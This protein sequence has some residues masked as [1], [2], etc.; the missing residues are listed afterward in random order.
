[1]PGPS[2]AP[3]HWRPEHNLI[4]C[5]ARR[6]LDPERR[7]R[8][9]TLT[10]ESLDWFL[11]LGTAGD[12]G[13]EPLLYWHLNSTGGVVVPPIWS[14][15][16]K[17]AFERNA[18]RNLYMSGQL[19]RV[20]DSF[21]ANGVCGIPYK[22]PTLA[23][24]AYGNLALRAS[25][26]LDILVRQRDLPRAQELLLAL[27]YSIDLG[28]M[29]NPAKHSERIPGQYRF[30]WDYG[31]VLVELHT[32]RTL[33]YFPAPLDMDHL[34]KRLKPIPLGGR[35]VPTFSPEDLLTVLCVHGAKHFWDRLQWI[36]DIAELA[37][38]PRG[39]NW[40]LAIERAGQMQSRRMLFLGLSLAHELLGANLPEEVLWQIER[41]RPVQSLAAQVRA[42]LFR[43]DEASPNAVRRMLFRIRTREKVSAG[44]RYFCR[45][46]TAPTEEDWSR[47]RLPSFLSPLYVV[48]RP[49]HLMRRYGLGLRH[50]PSRDLAWFLPTPTSIAE[51]M[52]ELAQVR[53]NDVLYDLG[54]G[55]GQIV[56]TAAKRYGI[57]CVGVDIDP[58]RIAEAKANARREG[59]KHLVKFLQQDAKTAV[60]TPATIVTLYLTELGSAKVG[61]RLNGQLRPG[62]RVVS[63]DCE[64]PGWVPEKTESVELPGSPSTTLYLWRMQA[65]TD[66][67]SQEH[68]QGVRGEALV[69]GRSGAGAGRAAP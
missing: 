26:D 69:H 55:N 31:R 43:G 2:V 29:G 41:D 18:R 60:V 38:L 34:E 65:G 67:S 59:V 11:V 17:R 25:G 21:E 23:A 47:L 8:L 66:R 36:A 28:W 63:R 61:Q 3:A 1:M 20:L 44:L 15:F 16:L 58:Q 14:D 19:L 48:I 46:A 6:A 64:I 30:S 27:G 10:Q 62:T 52:L 39:I 4:L 42:L 45:L 22:G 7:A 50:R 24:L 68:G 54:C 40:S 33:R 32:E 12:Q 57:R 13:V 51:R 35:E 53:S 49:L 37:E 5:S 56:V 9:R